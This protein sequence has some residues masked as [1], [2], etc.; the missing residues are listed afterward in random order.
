MSVFL[1]C[2]DKCGCRRTYFKQEVIHLEDHEP[3]VVYL[4]HRG[5]V[6]QVVY[7]N[8]GREKILLILKK[9]DIFGEVAFFQSS[10]N[11]VLSQAVAISEIAA[12]GDAELFAQLVKH[13]ELYRAIVD[14]L[15]YKMRVLVSQIKDLSFLCTEGKLLSLLL[16]LCAQHGKV[17]GT[18]E[19]IIE[20][21]VT[22]QEL[23]NMIATY[24]ST[25]SRIL[26]RLAVKGLISLERRNLIVPDYSALNQHFLELT[27]NGRC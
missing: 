8:D 10:E 25:V 13:P 27:V 24:R 6:K 11:L 5:V 4:I 16:R 14:S 21:D 15:S 12:I 2:L 22:H 20:I 1:E 18:G 26:R 7:D 19:I 3:R 17:K 23:A 9:G